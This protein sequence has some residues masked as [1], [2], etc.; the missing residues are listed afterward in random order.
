MF[1]GVWLPVKLAFAYVAR[2]A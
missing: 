1:V 2:A